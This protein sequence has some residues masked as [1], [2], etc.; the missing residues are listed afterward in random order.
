M[1]IDS[2]SAYDINAYEF[3]RVRDHSEIGVDVVEAWGRTLAKKSNV[4]ELACGGGY[5]ITRVLSDAGMR[6]WA[7]ESA[8]ALLAEFR[9]RFPAVTVQCV[10]VQE[11]DFFELSFDA[12]VAVGLMFLLTETEQVALINRV[13]QVLV[14]GGRFLFSAPI[15][16]C[17]WTDITTGIVSQSL[18]RVAYEA[19]LHA[20]GMCLLTLHTD[21]GENNYYD[22]KRIG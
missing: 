19:C 8:P 7:V 11:S 18:G 20:A 4:L 13:A 3:L 17:S 6:L 22:A 12:V 14:P 9:R 10:T 16:A 21:S 15:Q 1:P 5:P 2:A